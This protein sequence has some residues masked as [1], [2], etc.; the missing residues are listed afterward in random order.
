M[1]WLDING[2]SVCRGRGKCCRR[3]SE[4]YNT[5]NNNMPYNKAVPSLPDATKA[6]QSWRHLVILDLSFLS[7]SVISI[8]DMSMFSSPGTKK[9]DRRERIVSKLA[10]LD[11][12]WSRI[13][14]QNEK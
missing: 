7:P 2:M 8:Q 5:V 11:V 1:L 6:L 9:E 4:K 10:E 13:C 3:I 14:E 12:I